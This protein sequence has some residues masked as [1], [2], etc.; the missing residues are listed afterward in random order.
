MSGSEE[1]LATLSGRPPRQPAR[2]RILIGGL[3][4]GLTLRAA[5]PPSAPRRRSPWPSSCRPSSLGPAVRSPPSTGRASTIRAHHARGDVRTPSLPARRSMPS[6][7][8]RQWPRWPFRPEN[9]RL[10]SAAGL[11]A[12]RR[13]SRGRAPG[14]L[15]R[16]SRRGLQ[17]APRPVRHGRRG[18]ARARAQQRQGRAPS[19]L[20]CGQVQVSGQPASIRSSGTTIWHVTPS[21]RKSSDN[22]AANRPAAPR[23]INV[24]PKP[25][26]LRQ[27]P[28]GDRRA[29]TT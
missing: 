12:S 2:A 26:L 20:V 14:R 17:Q 6:A 22:L 19:Y 21:G 5:L 29:P 25:A 3:G 28:L 11:A 1:Q 15:V 18:S 23:S 27:V 7:R 24:L 16:L 13:P 4:H 9:D 8:C 10:Y